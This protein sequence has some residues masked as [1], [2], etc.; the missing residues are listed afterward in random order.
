VSRELLER[1][2]EIAELGPTSA[3]SLPVR[4]VFVQ[5]PEAKQRLNPAVGATIRRRR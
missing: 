3:N 5:S 1:A 2:V 4:Y